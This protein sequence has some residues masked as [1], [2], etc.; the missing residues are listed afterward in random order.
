MKRVREE[1]DKN[2]IISTHMVAPVL[3]KYTPMQISNVISYTTDQEFYEEVENSDLIDCFKE[4]DFMVKWRNANTFLDKIKIKREYDERIEKFEDWKNKNPLSPISVSLR[5]I[6]YWLYGGGLEIVMIKTS[7][8]TIA[9]GLFECVCIETSAFIKWEYKVKNLQSPTIDEID[10]ECKESLAYWCDNNSINHMQNCEASKLNTYSLST[11][12]K[13]R[14][15]YKVINQILHTCALAF[16]QISHLVQCFKNC[17]INDGTRQENQTD[18]NFNMPSFTNITERKK[19]LIKYLSFY[20][21]LSE[22]QLTETATFKKFFIVDDEAQKRIRIDQ[23]L[24]NLHPYHIPWEH[25]RQ[26]NK[27]NWFWKLDQLNSTIEFLKVRDVDS[28]T[29]KILFCD[30]KILE[31]VYDSAVFIL[32]LMDKHLWE[33]E[34]KIL[35]SF[36]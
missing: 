9:P 29:N 4:F 21:P 26:V 5:K 13:I 6:G 10:K 23:I 18:T 15:T 32:I 20:N 36:E 11:F 22:K 12:T 30:M 25:L 14:Y 34:K 27:I 8:K 1:E 16:S 7:D 17:E 24:N 33:E 31:Y 28:L 19:S 35:L 3:K 2:I